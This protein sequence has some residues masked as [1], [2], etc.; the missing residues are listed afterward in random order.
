VRILLSSNHVYPADTR[1]GSGP[2]PKEL[3]S[4][5]GMHMHDLLAKG[6]AELGHEILY[7]LPKGAAEPLPPGVEL[8][9]EPTAD[10]DLYHSQ[11]YRDQ[12]VVDFM[13]AR[14]VPWVTTCHLDFKARGWERPAVSREWIYVS[15]S[16]AESHGSSRYVYNGIDPAS[17]LFSAEKENYLL[18]MAAMDWSES[19]GLDTALSL[20][21]E[22]GVKLVVAGSG[23][24]WD[25]VRA[26]AEC[27]RAVG[28]EYV[29][30]VRGKVR[31][32]LLSR[33]R[34]VILPT[35]VNEAFGLV[36]VEALMSGTPVICSNLGACPEIVTPDV[37]FVCRT[38]QE[39]LDA[40]AGAHRVSPERCRARAWSEFRYSTMAANYVREYERELA[41]QCRSTGA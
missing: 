36:L 17:F 26:A 40:I 34:A 32:E 18:F 22:A 4:G 7:L 1:V 33:A 21:A 29:G 27:C 39:Y 9:S 12:E 8:I 25:V 2:Q 15:R 14:G 35:K 19:K 13:A 5:S 11:A 3:P 38:R 23:K 6:L 28:A 31:A 24:T 10:I 41:G 16:L 20:A 37:G 30:D